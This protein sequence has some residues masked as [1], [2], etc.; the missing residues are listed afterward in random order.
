MSFG[1]NRGIPVFYD[2]TG[3]PNRGNLEPVKTWKPVKPNSSNNYAYGSM[4]VAI[5][6]F[7]NQ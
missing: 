1:K 3:L 4:L 6:H 7:I 5:S 2:R